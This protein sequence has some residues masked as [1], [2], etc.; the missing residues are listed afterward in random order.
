MDKELFEVFYEKNY[1]KALGFI[2]KYRIPKQYAEDLIQDI[3]LEVFTK[4]DEDYIK[5]PSLFYSFLKLRV[6]GEK[7]NFKR[8]VEMGTNLKRNYRENGQ[9][10]SEKRIYK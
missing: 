3:F 1:K 10:S 2:I 8:Q 9:K 7:R 6:A 4:Y 5:N